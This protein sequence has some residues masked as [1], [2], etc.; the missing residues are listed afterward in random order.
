MQLIS[1]SSTAPASLGDD[2]AQAALADLI[3]LIGEPDFG[4][5]A[6]DALN[7]WLP[8]CWWSVY[9]LYPEAPPALHAHGSAGHAPEGT[10]DSWRVYRQSLYRRDAT[11]TAAR[12]AV[13]AGSMALVHW[14]AAEIPSDHRAAIYSR[15]GLRERL[16]IVSGGAGEGLLAVNLYRHEH[17]PAL[18]GDAVEAI[19]RMARPLLACVRRH[20][21][22]A[23]ATSAPDPGPAPKAGLQALAA[24]TPREREVCER[25]LR[26]WTHAGIAA[27][28]GLTPATVRTYRDRAF[29]RLGIRSRHALFARVAGTAA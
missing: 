5:S 8:L 12:E 23:A 3:G 22:L 2:A 10:A 17:Q 16:S 9:T 11:F 29:D 14:T 26:G 15:N 7:R 19:G 24:L 4:A 18:G 6:L 27:D 20:I 25:L 21:A 1:L 13:S 28:L